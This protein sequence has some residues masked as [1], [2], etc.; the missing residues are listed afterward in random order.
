[1]IG[2]SVVATAIATSGISIPPTPRLRRNG[3]GSTTSESSPIATVSPLSTT[4]RPAVC[5][6]ATIASELLRPWPSS[7]RQRVTNQERVV[8]R[9]AEAN[10]RDEELDDEADRG[11]VRHPRD[12]QERRQ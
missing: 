12:E 8:D 1:M 10:E 9:D 6:A 11:Q 3:T 7:S 4:A 5:A 2:S